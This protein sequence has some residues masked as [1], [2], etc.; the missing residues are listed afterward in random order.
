MS[1][2]IRLESPEFQS[3][4]ELTDWID[5]LEADPVPHPQFDV[6]TVTGVLQVFA[7]HQEEEDVY[8]AT[9]FVLA[10]FDTGDRRHAKHNRWYNDSGHRRT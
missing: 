4:H 7:A 10:A 8:S 9:V 1:E 6:Y 5:T 3:Y 2:I